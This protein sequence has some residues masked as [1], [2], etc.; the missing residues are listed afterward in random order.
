MFEKGQKYHSLAFLRIDL[1][2]FYTASCVTF[3]TSVR[4]CFIDEGV[5]FGWITANL[6][7]K[8]QFYL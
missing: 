1:G 8:H 7:S 3:I 4:S 6:L 2:C 5:V